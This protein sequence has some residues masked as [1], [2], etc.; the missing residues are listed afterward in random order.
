M[1]TVVPHFHE[2]HEVM[3]I[4][5]AK[6][7]EEVMQQK[8]N[9]VHDPTKGTPSP[10]GSGGSGEG[11]TSS[12][13]SWAVEGLTKSL[14]R[15]TADERSGSSS[16]D[17]TPALP[18]GERRES[19]ER[20]QNS[21]SLQAW[22]S[23]RG[24]RDGT[25]HVHAVGAGVFPPPAT[26]SASDGLGWDDDLDM[27]DLLAEDPSLPQ[28]ANGMMDEIP[29]PSSSAL[30]LSQQQQETTPKAKRQPAGGAGGGATDGRSTNKKNNRVTK[31]RVDS[32]DSWD[33]F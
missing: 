18:V 28:D 8:A 1:D 24:G 32:D 11:N 6:K 15:A 27:D 25:N 22:S 21:N 26:A 29:P 20:A 16:M 10:P 7:K 2:R 14:E 9:Q 13:T 4:E 23:E 12:W 19:T 5:E 31:L 17:G 3:S 30:P 33:D